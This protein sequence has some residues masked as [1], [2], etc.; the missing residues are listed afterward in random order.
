[1]VIA[2]TLIKNGAL[3]K[4]SPSQV[5]QYANEQLCEGNEAELF[6][7]VWMAVIE[8]STGKGLAANAGHE[9][10]AIKRAD[11]KWELEVYRHSPAVAT[12]DGLKFSEHEFEL[13]PGD[14][15]FVYTDGVP[16]ATNS[17]NEMFGTDR[18]LDSLNRD[19]DADITQLLRT[20]KKDVDEF[21]GD[22]PQFDDVTML[23]LK[24]NGGQE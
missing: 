19:P 3:M 15:L 6:V 17:N 23:G 1:M 12:M 11:G 22:A 5:L 14:L 24:W 10:P 2:K 21:T 18:M 20:V 9:H 8:I 13:H 7:T 4:I 16:E